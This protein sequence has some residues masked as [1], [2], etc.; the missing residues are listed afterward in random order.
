M[1][2]VLTS[3]AERPWLGCWVR[4]LFTKVLP[5]PLRHGLS[6]ASIPGELRGGLRR[7]HQSVPPFLPSAV[8]LPSP[9]SD[10]SSR[11]HIHPSLGC[12]HGGA[13][14]WVF[15]RLFVGVLT[16]R[17]RTWTGSSARQ[18]EQCLTLASGLRMPCFAS[19][20]ASKMYIAKDDSIGGPKYSQSLSET[21]DP[22]E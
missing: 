1:S 6:I 16:G 13:G 7:M 14:A 20:G 8:P 22:V 19:R 11:E 3:W 12:W 10:G 15:G 21:P 2:P 17:S 18:Q 4:Q 9:W 5:L